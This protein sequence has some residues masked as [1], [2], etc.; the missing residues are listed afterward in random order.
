M[1]SSWLMV[2]AWESSQSEWV[3]TALVLRELGKR[4]PRVDD[5]AIKVM[6]VSSSSPPQRLRLQRQ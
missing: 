1:D 6:M 4:L 5:H 3:R 2:D